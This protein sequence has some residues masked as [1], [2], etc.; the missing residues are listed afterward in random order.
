[1]FS[2]GNREVSILS[3][4]W[5]HYLPTSLQTLSLYICGS[6]IRS[7]SI[8]KP[9]NHLA[10]S[11]PQ[12]PSSH[13][14][15]DLCSTIYLCLELALFFPYSLCLGKAP[16]PPPHP[17]RSPCLWSQAHPSTNSKDLRLK[18]LNSAI[19][20]ANATCITWKIKISPSG[21]GGHLYDS[22]LNQHI[23]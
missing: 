17:T 20:S 8:Q 21:P 16:P 23:A 12:T 13:Q 10:I 7:L 5:N 14:L 19:I 18:R 4:N 22:S 1:M 6:L 15:S 3:S 9:K 11:M 2:C